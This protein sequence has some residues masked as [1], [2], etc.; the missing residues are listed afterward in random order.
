M[1]VIGMMARLHTLQ[2]LL[3][4]MFGTEGI[5]LPHQVGFPVLELRS[6]GSTWLMMSP[7]YQVTMSLSNSD[8]SQIPQ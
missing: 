6:H 8:K 4:R 1:V 5:M 2:D 7:I 3:V